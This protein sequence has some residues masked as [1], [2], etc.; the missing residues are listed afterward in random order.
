MFSNQTYTTAA[1]KTVKASKAKALAKGRLW[2]NISRKF[3]T[4]VC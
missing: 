2:P 4:P 1:M 3:K